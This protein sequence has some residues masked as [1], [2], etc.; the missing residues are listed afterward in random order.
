[1]ESVIR[2]RDVTRR[3]GREVAFQ[4][5]SLEVPPG[6]VFGLL[7]ENG[8]GKTTAIRILLGLLRPNSGKAEVLG[9][10]SERDGLEIRRRVA[11]RPTL[12]EWMTVAEIG[13]FTEGFY[14]GDF[15]AN[16]KQLCD[17]F[18]L[19]PKKKLKTLS[20]GGRAKVALALAVAHDPALLGPGRADFGAR[21]A[22]GTRQETKHS[23]VREFS[24]AEENGRRARCTFRV[25]CWLRFSAAFLERCFAVGPF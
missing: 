2:L 1:M 12:Y 13:W 14:G 6:V 23:S 19:A 20:K 7:G 5:V 9:F 18:G 3:F 17:Q 25:V 10:D 22:A 16:Y 24:F 8:A 4:N 21:H 15:L 11:E